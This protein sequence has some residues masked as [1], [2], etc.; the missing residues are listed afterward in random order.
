M[1]FLLFSV[2]HY[3]L[4]LPNC[5]YSWAFV[6]C[7]FYSWQLI[8]WAILSRVIF[9]LYSY[10]YF[11]Y[12]SFFFFFSKHVHIVRVKK[13]WTWHRGDR[14]AVCLPLLLP[15]KYIPF[16]SHEMWI[17]SISLFKHQLLFHCYDIYHK[18]WFQTRQIHYYIVNLSFHA[19]D[20]YS[21][22]KT[23]M[24]ID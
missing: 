19:L 11:C 15:I 24:P 23:I 9:P 6:W 7:D 17:S 4:I 1:L 20:C 5:L 8:P 21:A 13:Q 2:T 3:K 18:Q 14:G 10:S 12:F 22:P 16:I